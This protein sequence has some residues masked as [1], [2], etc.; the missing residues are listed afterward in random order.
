M[1]KEKVLYEKRGRIA[2]ITINRPEAMNAVDAEVWEGIRTA[3]E[4]YAEDS[5]LWCAIITGAGDRAFC[6]GADLKAVA[7]GESIFPEGGEKWGFAGIAQHY[8]NKPIIA[9]VNG[10][11]LGGGTEIALACDLIVASEKAAFGLPEVK[12]GIIAGAGGLLRLP[13][14]LPLKV[15]M[16]L[17][18][19]GKSMSPQEASGWGLVNRVVPHAQLLE[20]AIELADEIIVNAPVAVSASKDIVYRGLDVPLDHPSKAWEINQEYTS[21]VMESQDSKEGPRA[22]AEKRKPEWAGR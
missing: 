3:L 22:F 12:R 21:R 2:I 14:Q 16:E 1:T 5:N 20:K 10:F 15:A 17:I 6:A 9:A 4:D 7:K 8:I 19:T 13:R 18:L 11:A